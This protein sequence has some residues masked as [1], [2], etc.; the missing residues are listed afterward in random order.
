MTDLTF[1]IR[2]YGR[3]LD[4]CANEDPFFVPHGEDHIVARNARLLDIRIQDARAEIGYARV[5]GDQNRAAHWRYMVESLVAQ[6]NNNHG[7]P[8]APPAD[9]RA[10]TKEEL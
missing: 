8:Y 10:L 7:Q 9:A 3:V 4:D 6:K 1:S 5:A 2:P